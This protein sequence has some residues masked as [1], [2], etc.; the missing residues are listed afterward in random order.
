VIAPDLVPMTLALAL[1]AGAGD[2]GAPAAAEPPPLQLFL[3]AFPVDSRLRRSLF[4]GAAAEVTLHFDAAGAGASN[5]LVRRL[6]AAIGSDGRLMLGSLASLTYPGAA[7]RPGR[8]HTRPSFLID[9]D[10]P[11]FKPVLADARAQLGAAPSID[12]VVR[13]VERFITNKHMGRGY[14]IASIVAKRREGDC[15]EHAVLLTALARAFKLPARVVSGLVLTEVEGR[16]LAFGH[17]WAE[18]FRAGRWQRADAAFTHPEKLIYLPLELV[19]D[20]G[21]GFAL[22]LMKTSVGTLGVRKISITEPG[23]AAKVGP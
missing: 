13:F 23:A 2:A 5:E 4:S 20:E 6:K 11:V 14:D 15:T 8:Q 21:P 12:A 1:A 3:G 18:V 9:F 10:E 7:D 16:Q 19:S 17:A 22:S